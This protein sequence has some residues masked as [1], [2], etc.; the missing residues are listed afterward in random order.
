MRAGRA[1]RRRI[2]AFFIAETQFYQRTYF[3]YGYGRVAVPV[4]L[5]RLTRVIKEVVNGV[6]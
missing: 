1:C 2:A 4:K 6:S 3:Q 5:G